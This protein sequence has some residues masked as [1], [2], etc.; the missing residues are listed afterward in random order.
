MTHKAALALFWLLLVLVVFWTLSPVSFR[1]QFGRPALERAG[2]FCALAGA[3]GTAYPRRLL[4]VAVAICAIAIGSEAL[5]LLF[6]SRHA[7]LIDAAEKTVGGLVGAAA[8]AVG[9]RFWRRPPF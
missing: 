6:A 5:Q 4:L 3:L 1:P 7:R 9:A 8:V 2:A